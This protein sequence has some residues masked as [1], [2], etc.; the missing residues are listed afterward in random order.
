MANIEIQAIDIG[1][2]EDTRANLKIGQLNIIEGSSSSGKSSLMR[3]IHLALVGRPPLEKVYEEETEILHL[4]DRTSDQAL[5]RR[6]SKEGSVLVKT[7]TITF[8]AT[9]PANG[10]IKG[11]NSSPK[12]LFTTML[13]AL[14]PSRIHRAVFNASANNPNDFKWVVDDLSDAGNYQ[15]WHSVLNAVDQEVGA[16]RL[17]FNSWKDSLAGADARRNEI[18][19]ELD[20]IQLRSAARSKGKGA[21]E[22]ALVEKTNAARNK[23]NTSKEEFER[24]D[25]EYRQAEALNANQKRRIDAA[26]TQQKTAQRKLDEAEDLLEMDFSEPDT[27]ALD[28]AI[29]SATA[30]VQ[31]HKEE[32]RDDPTLKEAIDAFLLDKDKI[33]AASPKFASLFSMVIA[34]QGDE[35]KLKQAVIE[36]NEA[37]SR[38]DTIVKSYLDKKRQFGMADQQAAAA[39][40]EIAASKATIKDAEQAMTT[41]SFSLTKMKEKRDQYE[42][43]YKAAS[44]ELEKLLSQ[45]DASDPEE[46]NDRKAER[47]LTDELATLENTTTF[48]IRFTSLNML[49]NQTMNLTLP[50][51]EQ[52]LGLGSSKE[53]N[54]EMIQNNLSKGAAEIRSILIAE[55]DRGLLEHIGSSAHWAAEEADRQR[56][57]TRRVFNNVGTTMFKRLKVSPITGVSLNIDYNIEINWADGSSTGLSGAGGERTII[58][59]ALLIAMRKAYTPEIPILMLDGVMENLDDRPREEL[60]AFL[61]EYAKAED[62]AVMIS[63]LNRDCDNAK[64]ISN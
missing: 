28:A 45:S 56:Q 14:P 8:S 62:I 38:R 64:V 3:G 46:V 4:G 29:A 31:A 58:A 1:G 60:A 42:T 19:T 57:E 2:L 55:L 24:L 22:A 26:M 30:K 54:K 21:A 10:I 17:K 16:L 9:L 12:A 27:S 52:F 6:G 61:G 23:K 34:G 32:A 53:A 37:K 11:Q 59:A 33:S 51:A 39:R 50:E 13:S 40:A 43:V 41:D 48:S 7:P 20:A 15:T 47:A 5:L 35:S 44:A 63:R 49:P 18:R 36:L 25:G